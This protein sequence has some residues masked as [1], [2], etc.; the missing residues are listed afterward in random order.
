MKT[1]FYTKAVLTVIALC[2][3]FQVIQEIQLIPTVNAG[4]YNT[5]LLPL[6]EDGSLNV[7]W[8]DNQEIDVVISGVDTYDELKV[9]VSEVSARE[10]ID[11]NID[12][13]GGSFVPMSG[14]IKVKLD[15]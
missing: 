6:N 15:Q 1:D 13:V 11:I 7:R 2:L 4:G 10:P 8:S 5:P 3:S 9:E 12:E 14:P